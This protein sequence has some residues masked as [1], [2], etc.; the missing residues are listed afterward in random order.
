[1]GIKEE[2]REKIREEGFFYRVMITCHD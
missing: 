1:M 2:G